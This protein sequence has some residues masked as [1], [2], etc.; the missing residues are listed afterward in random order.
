MPYFVQL[1]MLTAD[2]EH[3]P[4]RSVLNKAGKALVQS[5]NS[6]SAKFAGVDGTPWPAKRFRARKESVEAPTSSSVKTASL[7]MTPCPN[8]KSKVGKKQSPNW[9]SARTDVLD[10]TSCPNKKF[11]VVK[12]TVQSP[13]TSPEKTVAIVRTSCPKKKSKVCKDS[14]QSPNST[15]AKTAAIDGT[16]YIEKKPQISV[17]SSC[18]SVNPIKRKKVRA[19]EDAKRVEKV[20]QIDAI[21]SKK[22]VPKTEKLK[23]SVRNG[24]MQAV[25]ELKSSLSTYQS[26]GE[27]T[28]GE[29]IRIYDRAE[30]MLFSFI[31]KFWLFL[32]LLIRT[33]QVS[34]P[35]VL[36]CHTDCKP[37]ISAGT[38]NRIEVSFT[39]DNHNRDRI[40]NSNDHSAENREIKC[41]RF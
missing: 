33:S 10:R 5:P 30:S 3:R 28:S 34:T 23:S 41:K 8:K 24:S 16:S 1:G 12:E 27:K 13:N 18:H 11:K 26:A 35:F 29:V 21:S 2:K 17:E 20:P 15:S 39:V 7:D 40:S 31:Y 6:S 36:Q 37:I 38:V 25:T 4:M 14:L 19:F 22:I 9:N 32:M